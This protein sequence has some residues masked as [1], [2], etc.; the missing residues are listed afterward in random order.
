MA[1]ASHG[2]VSVLRRPAK[3]LPTHSRVARGKKTASAG[4]AGI[5]AWPSKKPILLMHHRR[6]SSTVLLRQLWKNVFCLKRWLTELSPTTA[7]IYWEVHWGLIFADVSI[8]SDTQNG[9]SSPLSLQFHGF[10]RSYGPDRSNRNGDN[11]QDLVQLHDS[12]P[13]LESS[14]GLRVLGVG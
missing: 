5:C 3:V 2:P 9:S 6:N 14:S 13:Q 10:R 1:K 7:G 4:K 11:E 8:Y 12:P